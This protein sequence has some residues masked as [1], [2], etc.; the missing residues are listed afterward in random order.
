[1]VLFKDYV[2]FVLHFK[3]MDY[4]RS[5]SYRLFLHKRILDT[6]LSPV[7][8]IGQNSEPAMPVMPMFHLQSGKTQKACA[9]SA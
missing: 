5:L 4:Y 9:N 6:C 3:V 1:M 8:Y 7:R 2:L